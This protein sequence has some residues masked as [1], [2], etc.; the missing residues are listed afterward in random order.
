MSQAALPFARLE[1]HVTEWTGYYS[2]EPGRR[3]WVW[4]RGAC[5]D[6]GEG[7][8]PDRYDGLPVVRWDRE[9]GLWLQAVE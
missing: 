6:S 5:I 7:D 3:W 8:P 4:D 9:S 2:D 1:V